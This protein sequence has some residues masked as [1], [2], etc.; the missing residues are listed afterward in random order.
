MHSAMKEA[1]KVVEWRRMLKEVERAGL[2]EWVE[3]AVIHRPTDYSAMVTIGGQAAPVKWGWP[4]AA[5]CFP[6]GIPG[7]WEVVCQL[8]LERGVPDRCSVHMRRYPT[9]LQGMLATIRHL[10]RCR[11]VTPPGSPR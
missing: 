4:L 5:V 10:K 1:E 3:G 9:A 8:H 6:C 7:M 11:G 2:G